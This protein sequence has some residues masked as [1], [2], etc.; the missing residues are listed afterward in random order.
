MINS[1]TKEIEAIKILMEKDTYV[2]MRSKYKGKGRPRSCDYVKC[3]VKNIEM[4][5]SYDLFQKAFAEK[6]MPKG[7]RINFEN[8]MIDYLKKDKKAREEVMRWPTARTETIKKV[9]SEFLLN[10]GW[11]TKY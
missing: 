2:L 7:D 6:I 11:K 9:A 5:N 8:W 1:D 10:Y 3:K 4:V